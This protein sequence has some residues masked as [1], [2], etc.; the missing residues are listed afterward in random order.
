M[1]PAVPI[2]VVSETKNNG[3]VMREDGNY[4]PKAINARKS[5]TTRILVQ[6][7]QAG[8]NLNEDANKKKQIEKEEPMKQ[9]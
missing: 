9:I 4:L 1:V 6:M 3:T 2:L 5:N 7:Y 8:K